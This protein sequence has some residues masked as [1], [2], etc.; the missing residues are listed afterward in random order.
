MAP[1]FK[2]GF[3]NIALSLPGAAASATSPDPIV[4]AVYI[5]DPFASKLGSVDAAVEFLQSLAVAF[6]ADV[7]QVAVN[8]FGIRVSQYSLVGDLVNQILLNDAANGLLAFDAGF[9]V[10]LSGPLSSTAGAVLTAPTGTV[11]PWA[12]TSGDVIVV[13]KVNN[14]TG[15]ATPPG[16]VTLGIGVKA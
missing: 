12:L 15:E 9:P 8:N 10:D 6:A 11:L 5:Y 1:S 14:G 13:E 16:G 3:R 7:A 2:V 4:G